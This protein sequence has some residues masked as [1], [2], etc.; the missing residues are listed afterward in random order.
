MS[1]HSGDNNMH[2]VLGAFIIGAFALLLL[3]IIWWQQGKIDRLEESLE[4]CQGSTAT[5]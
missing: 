3:S 4:A 5:E 1:D 2:R